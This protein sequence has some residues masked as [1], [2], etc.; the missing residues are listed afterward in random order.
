M[1][2]RDRGRR[3]SRRS[4][5]RSRSSRVV[6][7]KE[8]DLP[9]RQPTITPCSDATGAI[10]RTA[11]ATRTPRGTWSISMRRSL[12]YFLQKY[13]YSVRFPGRAVSSISAWA[14]DGRRRISQIMSQRTSASTCL[15]RWWLRAAPPTRTSTFV[16]GMPQ[17]S[18]CSRM[19]RSM[20]SC[21][22]STASIAFRILI[23]VAASRRPDESWP[24]TAGSCS[25]DTTRGVSSRCRDRFVASRRRS[26]WLDC[27]ELSSHRLVLQLVGSS[28]AAFWR[29]AGT[30]LDPTHG[31][32]LLRV[33][34]PARAVAELEEAGFGKIEGPL[35]LE[36]PRRFRWWRTP[37]YY[38]M[39]GHAQNDD[40][41]RRSGSGGG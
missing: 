9:Q 3:G 21:S 18:R 34:T 1:A 16:S 14:R 36:H 31:G 32:M 2:G 40:R 30:D 39:V 8:V 20:W 35:P 22:R 33:A 12:T 19:A 15:K 17:I 27:R 5:R 23:G 10:D 29:G 13:S 28:G 4:R 38:L 24:A 37:W 26:P 11:T 7:A 41:S 6:R 25:R